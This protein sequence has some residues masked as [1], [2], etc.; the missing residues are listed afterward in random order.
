MSRESHRYKLPKIGLAFLFVTAVLLSLV[1][2][3]TA[4]LLAVEAGKQ[5]TIPA[6]MLAQSEANYQPDNNPLRFGQLNPQIIIQVTKDSAQLAV[7]P[8][9]KTFGESLRDLVPDS[10]AQLFPTPLPTKLPIPEVVN[11]DP[12]ILQTAVP[13][14]TNTDTPTPAQPTA[15]ATPTITFTP[16]SG[17]TQ[18]ATPTQ[19]I[20]ATATATPWPTEPPTVTVTPTYP[21]LPTQPPAPTSTNT[22]VPPSNTA[23]ATAPATVTATSTPTATPTVTPT[24]D[25][26][27]LVA[28]YQFN[29]SSGSTAIDSSGNNNHATLVNG[30]TWVTGQSGNAVNLDGTDDYISMP[31]GIIS[32]LNDFTI[33]SWVQLDTIGNWQRLFDFG[34]GTSVNMFLVPHSFDGTVRFAIT[35]GSWPAEERID[36]I[37]AL[38]TGTWIHVAVTKSGNVGTLYVNGTTVGINTSMTLSPSSLG[39]TNQNWLGKSQYA[40]DAYLDGQLDDFRIYNRALSATE[41]SNL[42]SQ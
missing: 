4:T 39:S 24:P 25:G 2:V 37:P 7:T 9:A 31:T 26:T 6:G 42:F 18:T 29:E 36:G 17:P 1:I 40:S 13:V 35:T 21:P 3:S 30:P 33:A 20:V 8:A 5:D 32:S 11:L 16:T 10:I 19:V 12:E 28:W 23:T 38:A 15:S 22:A 34:T 27:G 14:N 41:I